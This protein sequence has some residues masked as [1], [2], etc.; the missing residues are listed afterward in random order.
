MADGRKAHY[1]HAMEAS[2]IL[3]T[4]NRRTEPP[5]FRENKRSETISI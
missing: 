5:D 2:A 4:Q 1:R 3:E